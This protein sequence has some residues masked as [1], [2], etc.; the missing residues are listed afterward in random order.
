[1]KKAIVT[2]LFITVAFIAKA[3]LTPVKVVDTKISSPRQ[4]DVD[5]DAPASDPN[6]KFD[7]NQIYTAVE[8]EP[9]FPGGMGEF[10]KFMK[11]NQKLPP[12]T[13]NS[14]VKVFVNFI[15]EKD[16]SLSNLKVLRSPS[17]AY[18]IEAVRILKLSPKWKPG[19]QN[20]KPVRCYY[21]MPIMFGSDE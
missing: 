19:I 2:L 15:V 11:T 3:Q 13:E 7:S 20:R 16:G 4:D 1:M 9:Q 12:G 18:S 6:Q 21:T 8:V 17:D 10:I 14:A 5:I